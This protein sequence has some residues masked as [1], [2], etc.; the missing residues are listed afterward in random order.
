MLETFHIPSC[1]VRPQQPP[2]GAWW[3]QRGWPVLPNW[4]PAPDKQGWETNEL[5]LRIQTKPIMPSFTIERSFTGIYFKTKAVFGWYLNMYS[6]DLLLVFLGGSLL[7]SESVWRSA[8]A[9]SMQPSSW[10]R[11]A[12]AKTAEMRSS[13]KSQY[14]SW[15]QPAPVWSV[16][17]RSMRWLLRWCWSWNCECPRCTGHENMKKV[18]PIL[19]LVL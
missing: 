9:M 2:G 12:R 13:M 7:W 16:F 4:L 19:V 17:I 1:L 8:Q 5:S 10:E 14:S 3:R 18:F 15:P 6:A 11:D